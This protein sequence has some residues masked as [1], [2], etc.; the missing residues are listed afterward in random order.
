MTFLQYNNEFRIK[1]KEEEEEDDDK[2]LMHVQAH[3]LLSKF[4]CPLI[5]GT[6]FF[7]LSF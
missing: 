3:F 1:L 5:I 7:H 2:S 4:N 6:L